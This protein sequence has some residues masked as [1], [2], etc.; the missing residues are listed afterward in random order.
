VSGSDNTADGFAALNG[1]QLGNYDT[2]I[3]SYSLYKR[4]GGRNAAFGY[5]ALANA[6]TGDDN[7][8]VGALAGYNVGNGSAPI[9]LNEM[10]R[11]QLIVST[12]AAKIATQ[13]ARVRELERQVAELNDLRAEMRAALNR[14]QSND[15]LVADR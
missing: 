13:D 3:G 5:Q 7:I 8:A 4:T 6:T 15:R 10:Q 9:L 1:N 2:A 14:L 11:Q 12:Q